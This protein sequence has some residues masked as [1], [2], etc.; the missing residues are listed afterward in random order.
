[1]DLIIQE[2]QR[3]KEDGATL[4]FFNGA[5]WYIEYNGIIYWFNTVF[6]EYEKQSEEWSKNYCARN[7]IKNDFDECIKSYLDVQEE[8][9]KI[10]EKNNA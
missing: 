6:Q 5:D 9:R 8:N 1:M 2:I 7:S 3:I 10:R 4:R